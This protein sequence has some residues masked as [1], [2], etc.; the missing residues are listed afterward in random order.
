MFKKA[1]FVIIN[2]N[3]ISHSSEY[4][5]SS[6]K[7]F[8]IFKNKSDRFKFMNERFYDWAIYDFDKNDDLNLLRY[9]SERVFEY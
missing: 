2:L 4:D 3:D 6:N 7:R 8:R 1:Y 5:K 9:S